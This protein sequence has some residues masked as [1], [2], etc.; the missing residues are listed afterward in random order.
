MLENLPKVVSLQHSMLAA[1]YVLMAQ[2]PPL[3]CCGASQLNITMETRG[4]T[5]IVRTHSE[6]KCG[7]EG[8]RMYDR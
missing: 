4:R 2:E 7:A 6:H 1:L 5:R 8:Q 3:C